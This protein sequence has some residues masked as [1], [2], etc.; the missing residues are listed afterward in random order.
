[1]NEKEC[2]KCKIIQENS[3][4]M[5]VM[6][7]MLV[8]DLKSDFLSL[9]VQSDDEDFESEEKVHEG[10]DN[11]PKIIDERHDI[12][13]IKSGYVGGCI[14][15]KDIEEIMTET[16]KSK[17]EEVK[18]ILKDKRE[19]EHEVDDYSTDSEWDSNEEESSY[20]Y[21]DSLDKLFGG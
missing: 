15:G 9:T 16:L 4:L 2:V 7:E 8:S 21:E 6:Y 10:I 12:E 1:M 3:A 20:E 11:H 17:E 18:K 19:G 5:E 13:N 14:M